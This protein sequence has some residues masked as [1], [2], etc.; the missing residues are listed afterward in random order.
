METPDPL[1]AAPRPDDPRAGEP[2]P[3]PEVWARVFNQVRRDVRMPTVWLAM[4]AAIP[5]ALDGNHF[6]AGLPASQQY[7]AVNLQDAQAAHAIEEALQQITGR[8]L[9]FT[10]IEGETLADWEA[11]K[12]AAAPAVMAPA[13]E[14]GPL[15]PHQEKE[16]EGFKPLAAAHSSP[17]FT[18]A[19]GPSRPAETPRE[20]YPTWEKLNERLAHGYKTAPQIRHAHGQARYILEAVRFI[21]DTMDVMMPGPGEPRDDYQER[22]LTKTLEKFSSI[23]TLDPLFLSLELLRYRESRGKDVGL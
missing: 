18:G 23:V 4:Q 16:S 11:Q 1:A 12:P 17:P 6:V 2:M 7:L 20:V 21:S 22:M 15:F 10:L 14:N 3:L 13:S 9:A 19:S 8:V 5:L